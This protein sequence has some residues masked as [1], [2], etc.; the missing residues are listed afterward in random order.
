[1]DVQS[2]RLAI[3]VTYAWRRLRDPTAIL[4]HTWIIYSY[5]LQIALRDNPGLDISSTYSWNA[6][7]ARHQEGCLATDQRR[8][9]TL[10]V[11][12]GGTVSF[13]LFILWEE[14]I[15][16]YVKAVLRAIYQ[17]LASISTIFQCRPQL[18]VTRCLLSSSRSRPRLKDTA[19]DLPSK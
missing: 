4:K 10:R 17:D 13:L 3:K 7:L 18:P 15:G 9:R 5:L 11:C 6:S 12:P 2:E 14:E 19:T 8:F 1:M 16:V